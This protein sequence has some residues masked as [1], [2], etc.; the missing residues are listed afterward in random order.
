MFLIAFF[1]LLMIFFVVK[2]YL[3]SDKRL[4]FAGIFNLFFS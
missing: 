2:K 3:F 4:S 1:Y